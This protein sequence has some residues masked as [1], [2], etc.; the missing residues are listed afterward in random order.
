MNTLFENSWHIT[1]I[2]CISLKQDVDKHPLFQHKIFNLLQKKEK[3]I[4]HTSGQNVSRGHTQLPGPVRLT[5]EVFKT[6]WDY[7]VQWFSNLW[8]MT[9]LG[10][11]WH[12][13]RG[14]ISDILNIIY[15]QYDSYQYQNYSYEVALR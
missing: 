14:H 1:A 10:V 4:N 11:E 3:K 7:I 2:R 5:Q 8:A 15:L 13:H 9:C 6:T 12:F